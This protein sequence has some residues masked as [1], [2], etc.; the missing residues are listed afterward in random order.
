VRSASILRVPPG[1]VWGAATSAFQIE[2]ASLEDGKGP[3]I[4]DT[5]CREPGRVAGGAT[6]DVAI[7]HYHR[8]RE[9]VALLAELGFDAYR[10]S[11]S[12]PR[13]MPDGR[14]ATSRAGLGFYDQLVDELLEAGL[15]PYPTLY[16]WDLPQALQDEGG[17]PERATASRFADYAA[18]IV[19]RLGDRV[20]RWATLNEPW[21]A[22]F[23]GHASGVHAPGWRDAGAAIA[24]SHHLLLAHGLAV[25]AM[26]AIRPSLEIGLVLNPAPVVGLDGVGDDAVRRI[27][28]LR[29]R[30]FLDPVLTGA[31][32]NDVLDD[33][34]A[35]LDDLIRPGDLETIAAP[36]DWLGVNYYHDLLFEPAVEPEP[37]PYPF[38]PPAR[39]AARTDL[40]TDLG[41]PVTPSGL[42][43]LL[44]HLRDTYPGLPRLAVTENGAAFTDPLVDGRVADDRR[45]TYLAEHLEALA[46]A[47]ADGVDVFAYFVWS[48]FD[49]MEWHDG[50]GPRFGVIHVDYETMVRTPKDSAL[51][52]REVIDASRPPPDAR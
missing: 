40:V 26:R 31:Y 13:V 27:D 19:Q 51:W 35:V 45:I 33:V 4:W 15:D 32:P 47:M 7:D 30:W 2:G 25:D 46:S 39:L 5:F 22:A 52:L 6:G 41:W 12:W 3:S 20:V 49:N 1:F 24:A 17:W 48:A 50:Y 14:G 23:L 16:H 10:F 29:N 18:T 43:D 21:C 8:H 38:V 28:G 42:A 44:R 11:I 37:W 9:D 36:L 34:A